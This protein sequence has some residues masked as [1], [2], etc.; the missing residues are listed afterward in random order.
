MTSMTEI[1]RQVA[2]T[3]S[4]L[5]TVQ[6]RLAIAQRSATPARIA[7]LEEQVQHLQERLDQ[8]SR[9]AQT[10]AEQALR[11]LTEATSDA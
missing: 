3:A 1:E 5:R 8:Q 4:Q 6:H 9:A 10:A 7:E 2:D 11:D